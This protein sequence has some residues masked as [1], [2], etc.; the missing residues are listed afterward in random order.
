MKD[1]C[2]KTANYAAKHL[3]QIQIP[4]AN[5]DKMRI[6]LTIAFLGTQ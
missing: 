4:R 5:P 2:V 3:K 1:L 6:D